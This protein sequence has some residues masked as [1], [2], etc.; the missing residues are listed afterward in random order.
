MLQETLMLAAKIAKELKVRPEQVEKTIA[1]LD[2]G[3]TVPFIARYRKEL[4]GALDDI[5][6][7]TLDAR[8]H[9]LRELDARR[10]VIMDAINDQGKLNAELEQRIKNADTKNTLE[11][12][13]LPYRPKRRTKALLAR[14]AGIEP[15]V[16]LIFE[17]PDCQPAQEA[18]GFTNAELGFVDG[19]AV[20]EGAKQIIMERFSED[21]AL[22]DKLRKTMWQHGTIQ[23]VAHKDLKDKNSKFKDYF[24]H[25][26]RLQKVPSHRALALFRGRR[27]C[28]LQLRIILATE[29]DPEAIIC[30]YFAIEARQD[31]PREKWLRE[32]VSL[33]W[34]T[35][36][37]TKLELE[38]MARLRE[39]ADEEATRV[40]AKNL[41]DLMLAAPAGSRTTLG[42]DPGIRTGIKAAVIDSTG[43]LLDYTTVFPLAPQND[44]HGAIAELAK[45]VAKY[46][47][48][49]V[50]IGNGT[51]SREAERLVNELQTT[52]K[53]LKL[54]KV[55]VSEAGASVYSASEIASK[56][57]PDLDVTIRGAV[58][59]A[60]RV[61]DPLAELVKIDPKA[62]GVGQYQHDINQSLLARSLD[63]VVED[64]VNA[65]GV[66]INMASAPLLSRIAGLSETL[67]N[68]IVD[69]RNA[70]GPFT[71]RH[72]LLNVPRMG[73]KSFQQA[74]GFLR[75]NQ[76]VNPLDAS[77]V[78]PEAYSLVEKI[79]LSHHC[80][81]QQLI[82]NSALLSAINPADYTDERFGM[83]TVVDVLKELEKPGRDPRPQFRTVQ[84][85]E[86]IEDISDLREGMAL[87]GVVSNVTNF[88]VFV[89][90]GV[91]QDG[92]VHI[93][94]MT[95]RFI[96]D[97]H[98]LVKA[99]DIIAVKVLEVDQ[100]RRR[101]SLSMKVGEQA[102]AAPVNKGKRNTTKPATKLAKGRDTTR[103]KPAAKH[104]PT[105]EK[106]IFN[107]VM[108]D[109]L[110]KLKQES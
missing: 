40:F 29:I 33:A 107:T 45:L 67:A 38:L 14:E 46:H 71:D 106:P 52:Y 79:G 89:D 27:E 99:G 25:N 34:K 50:S 69:Y 22:L 87:E 92:L 59:I 57:F 16:A 32:V 4:T 24:N 73:E 54:E 42:L 13:Y 83:P 77:S 75:V 3:A 31:S 85:K 30:N 41:R 18:E 110:K 103:A 84:F 26:E 1:L 8:L 63:A 100:K 93:S 49:L 94:E 76:G 56:E 91:H 109:A 51:G 2:D 108:A 62:I 15:L 90:I 11:D 36:L 74:A 17:K 97:P 96:N 48:G 60:R 10:Q 20:L 66:D 68:N 81:V 19:N 61:Q 6:L 64:C 21:A 104:K 78:H 105:P 86:G 39:S 88:G 5:Q 47:V 37:S 58:S 80:D 9:Y 95:H 70:H 102:P 7:R 23:A 72:T 35:K 44:W 101:I 98:Q 28:A 43:K 53:D 55:V 12:L 82:G 65:V